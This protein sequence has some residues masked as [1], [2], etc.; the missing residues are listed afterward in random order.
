MGRRTDFERDGFVAQSS[1]YSGDELLSIEDAL[2]RFIAERVPSLRPEH[3]FYEDKAD[4]ATLKQIQRLHEHDGF[5]ADLFSDKPK[6]L[7]QELL[8]EPVIGKNLQYFNKP[9]GAGQATPAHQDGYYFMLQPCHALTMWMA[10]DA[11]NEENGC[12]RYLA[13]SHVHGMRS[14]ARTQTLGFSQGISDYD[15]EADEVICL[16]QP[17]DLLTHHAMTIHRADANT[18]ISRNR[19]ALG[20]IFYGESAKEDSVAHATYQRQLRQEMI[21]QGRL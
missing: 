5:F 13:G 9:P 19:R 7:A 11:A 18:S 21:V 3:V 15:P 17:G 10:L 2:R 16:A 14:H 4:R 6:K 20:F 1:F 8:G 12:V